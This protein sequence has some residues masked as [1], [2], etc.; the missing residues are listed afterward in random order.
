MADD[1]PITNY[2]DVTVYG[3]DPDREAELIDQQNE[4]TFGWVTR[5]GSPMAAIMSYLEHDGKF[6]MTASG[7]RK[8]IAAV[9]RDPR[10]VVT[11]TS[12]GTKMGSGKTVTYKGIAAVHDDDE[13]KAWFYPALAERLMGR[14][15]SERVTEFANMLN[16]PRRV[17]ISIEKGTRVAY[18]G[19]KMRD[20]TNKAREAGALKWVD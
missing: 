3:L 13:T 9:R 17:I 14:W 18:D 6:W 16:S 7:Q 11:I 10:C 15:G 12:P 19:D 20:A 4:C 2:E 1:K 8:R 5:D